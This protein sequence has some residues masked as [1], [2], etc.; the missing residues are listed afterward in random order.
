MNI[1]KYFRVS[2]QTLQIP[3]VVSKMSLEQIVG[4][5]ATIT[6]QHPLAD[7]YTFFGNLEIN[8]GNTMVNGHLTIN[9]LMLR[10][11]RLKDTEYVVGYA[12]YTGQD[13][14][15]SLNSKIVRNKFSTAERWLLQHFTDV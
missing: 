7:L 9:N 11:S 3:K 10:G 4:A 6:C 5:E 1:S 13:T 2:F 12:I 15:L 14:K 8:D